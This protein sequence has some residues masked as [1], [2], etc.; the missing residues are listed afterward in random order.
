MIVSKNRNLFRLCFLLF[1]ILLSCGHE[2]NNIPKVKE[3]LTKLPELECYDLD[4]NK[5]IISHINGEILILNFWGTGCLPCILEIPG[6]NKLVEKYKKNKMIRFIAP[7]AYR[8]RIEKVKFFLE[9]NNFDF[10]Q[11]LIKVKSAKFLNI[12]S[13]PTTIICNQQGIILYKITGGHS[14]MY[15]YIDTLLN[16]GILTL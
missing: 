8:G 1:L 11:K 4:G 9:K 2:N 16:G 6:F 3:G 10:Q 12:T 7:H 5:E 13:V 15:K 14:E